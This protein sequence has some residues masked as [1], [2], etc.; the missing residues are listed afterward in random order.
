MKYNNG[1]K[2]HYRMDLCV[3]ESLAVFSVVRKAEKPVHEPDN[4][5]GITGRILNKHLQVHTCNGLM[6]CLWTS[7]EQM[8]S[9]C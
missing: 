5:G 9:L 2:E 7:T 3:L 8:L 4:C 6:K 1:S